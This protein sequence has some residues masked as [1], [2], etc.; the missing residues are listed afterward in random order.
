MKAWLFIAMSLK[1]IMGSGEEMMY[2]KNGD[3]WEG[4][5]EIGTA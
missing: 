3:D 1:V 4:T 5:C 2:L